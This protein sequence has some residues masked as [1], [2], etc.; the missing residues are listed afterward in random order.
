[1][2]Q[3]YQDVAP[4]PGARGLPAYAFIEPCHDSPTPPIRHPSNCRS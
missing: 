2:A 3:S 1:M 4:E